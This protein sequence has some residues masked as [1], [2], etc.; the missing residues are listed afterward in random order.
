MD[1]SQYDFHPRHGFLPDPDPLERLPEP[2]AAWE[3]LGRDLPKL[4]VADQ[5]RPRLQ[6]M[7]VFPTAALGGSREW[8]R[9]MVLL[10]YLGHAYVWGGGKAAERLPAA[11]ARPWH[12]VARRLGRPPVLSYASYALHNWRRL[13]P[14]RPIA[15]DNIALVQNFLG[16]LDEEW[17]ILIHVAIE[18]LAGPTLTAGVQARA[19]A[20]QGDVRGVRESLEAAAHGLQELVRILARMPESCDP[21]IYFHRVRP[22]IHG[23]KDN[24]ALPAGLVYEGVDE[25]GGV[26]QFFRGETGAQSSIIP[27][28]DALLGIQ[29]ADDPL[30]EYLLEMQDYMPPGHRRLIADLETNNHIRAFVVEHRTAYAVV[31][32]YNDCIT[33]VANFRSKHLDYAA[34][35]IH[36]QS[37]R[38]LSN[39]SAIGTGGTPFMAYLKKHRDEA[40]AH[41]IT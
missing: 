15:L 10:S 5:V 26:G 25:Y 31:E 35:Y 41:L 39:P 18:A 13:D 11:L 34:A 32:A 8:E 23:W 14:A 12:E 28:L 7:P 36:N 27:C 40:Q 3:A 17:F 6:G 33:W 22:Y 16:G 38:N 24:P 19:A 29:H 20:G 4:L 9:A 2:F 30:R 21:Y 1:L 37:Q